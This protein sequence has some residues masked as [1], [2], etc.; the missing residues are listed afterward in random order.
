MQKPK[1]NVGAVVV[2]N[3]RKFKNVVGTVKSINKR[4]RFVGRLPTRYYAEVVIETADGKIIAPQYKYV[5][6][7]VTTAQLK[8]IGIPPEVV[9]R[10]A[11]YKRGDLVKAQE[12]FEGKWVKPLAGPAKFVRCLVTLVY[13]QG[14]VI[15]ANCVHQGTYHAVKVSDLAVYTNQNRGSS[16]V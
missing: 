14:D 2:T 12:E 8:P 5:E 15:M 1:F 6:P 3:S 16:L 9:A 10:S 7:V 11:A 13:R 4:T